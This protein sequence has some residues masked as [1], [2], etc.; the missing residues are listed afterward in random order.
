[1]IYPQDSCSDSGETLVQNRN[2]GG[3]SIIFADKLFYCYTEREGEVALVDADSQKFEIISKFKVRLGSREHWARP[4][5][6][7]GVLYI[8]HG[9]AL[10]AYDIKDPNI[11]FD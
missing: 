9:E 6:H 4:V 11:N 1:L 7:Q 5:I 8:R 2:L 10:M 3:G